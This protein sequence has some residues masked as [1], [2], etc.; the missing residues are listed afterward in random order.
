M[1]RQISPHIFRHDEFALSDQ[2]GE[3]GENLPRLVS[4]AGQGYRGFMARSIWK[5][6][7]AF[8]LRAFGLRF[9][10]P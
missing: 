9:L 6:A 1:S 10:I 8:G 4:E 2:A 5:D 3:Q 7:I